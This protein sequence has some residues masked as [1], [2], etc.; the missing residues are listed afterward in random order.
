[1]ITKPKRFGTVFMTIAYCLVIM[2]PILSIILYSP[3]TAYASG[4]QYALYYDPSNAAAIK[5]ALGAQS[6]LSSSITSALND[7]SVY[8]KSGVFGSKPFAF[9][10]DSTAGIFTPS[11]GGSLNA[12]YD[13]NSTL[14]CTI[15]KNTAGNNFMKANDI[16]APIPLP[17]TVHI[18]LQVN[19]KLSPADIITGESALM[20]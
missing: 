7:T 4:E 8:A 14:D 1:M 3:G 11:A 10:Y 12:T 16:T 19:V 17:Y 20:M 5:A 2:L 6:P 15:T 9:T 18:P 13:S